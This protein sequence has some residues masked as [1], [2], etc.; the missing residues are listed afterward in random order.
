MKKII[1]MCSIM[2]ISG[3][4]AIDTIK[5]TASHAVNK[6]CSVPETGRNALRIDLNESLAPHSIKVTCGE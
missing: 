4:S 6:Y 5:L 3:C 2:S 1:I